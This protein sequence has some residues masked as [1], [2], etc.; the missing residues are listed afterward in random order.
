MIVR[1]KPEVGLEQADQAWFDSDASNN[2]DAIR[3]IDAE[4]N[5]YGLVRTREY[6]LQTFSTPDG[7]VVRRG[8]CYRPE[9]SEIYRPKRIAEQP[10]STLTGLSS[11]EIVRAMRD[12]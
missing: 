6:W 9:P 2:T 12:E 4:A 11:T 8:F 1:Y 3:E 5:Q 10:G 7:G